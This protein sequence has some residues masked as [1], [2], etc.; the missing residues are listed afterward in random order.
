MVDTPASVGFAPG[1]PARSGAINQASAL[2]DRAVAPARARQGARGRARGG[3]RPRS[4][5]ARRDADPRS[6]AARRATARCGSRAARGST[7]ASSPSWP[8][9]PRASRF[10]P[11]DIDAAQARLTRLGI[12][13]SIRIEEAEEIGPT[14]ACRSPSRVEDRRPR[15]IGFGGTLSTIDGLGVDAYWLHRNLLRPR[16][17]AALRRRH[18]RA[19]RLAQSRGLRL[20]RS[21]SPSPSRA[22]G[23]P[24]PTSSPRWWRSGSTTTPTASSRSPAGVGFSQHVRRPA[25]RRPLRRGLARPLRGRLR[26][27]RTSPPSRW[28]AAAPT[29]AATTRWTPPA[30]TIL[31]AEAPAVLRGRVRQPR[32]ARHARGPRLPSASA[33]RTAS[34]SPAGPRSAATGGRGIAESPPD[35]LFFAGGG[36]SVRGYA[37]R[38]IG[39]ETSI[40][41]ATTRRGRRPRPVRGLGRAALPHQRALRR[42]GLRRRGL[43]HRGSQALGRDATCASAPASACATIPASARSRFDLATP[44]D[45][46]PRRLGGGALHRDRTGVLKRLA[47]LL[48]VLVLA[49][50][51]ALAQDARRADDNGFLLNLLQNRLSD[52]RA[53]DPAERRHR[54]AVVAGARSPASPSPTPRAPGSRS[55]TPRSTGPASR[56]CAAGSTSTG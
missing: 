22:S 18:R 20:Q 44:I 39:V 43:R 48:G 28:S 30:A 13:R 12:F 2:V 26:H 53:A 41:T 37:Y 9:C 15:T 8:T 49:A 55:R 27:P 7:P 21:A 29:T 50:I 40:S 33:P 23:R 36:G 51:A 4:Q 42:G 34:C 10:D 52:P 54:R 3:R 24:T 16:R 47:A 14:A 38:S 25:D 1:E 32:G 45:P 19:R 46:R 17:A 6:R 31:A 56:C 5:P 11:D 35:L